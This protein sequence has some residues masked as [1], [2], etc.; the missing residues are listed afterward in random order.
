MIDEGRRADQVVAVRQPLVIV[1]VDVA[2]GRG[3]DRADRPAGQR[4]LLP[5]AVVGIAREQATVPADGAV[6]EDLRVEGRPV[7]GEPPDRR[8]VTV[9]D[10]GVV[11]RQLD[12]EQPRPA[13]ADGLESERA[14][15]LG[16]AADVCAT[17]PVAA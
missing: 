2:V 10:D 8:A 15:V 6:G 11:R 17:G 14:H 4:P 9:H 7:G 13:L 1:D 3:V 12:R 5:A 16:Q